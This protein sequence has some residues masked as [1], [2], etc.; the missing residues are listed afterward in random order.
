M[1][2]TKHFKVSDIDIRVT[3]KPIKN[4]HLSVHPPDGRVTLSSPPEFDLE[5]LRVYAATKLSWI[6]KERKKILSQER[7]GIKLYV[8]RESHQFLGKR[9]LLE[10]VESGRPKLI[11]LQNKMLLRAVKGATTEQKEK[12]LYNWYRKQLREIVEGLSKKHAAKMGIDEYNIGIRKMRTKWGS[13]TVDKR[14]WFNVELAK[15]PL[16][17]IEYVVV[18]E[19]VHILEK[20][21]NKRFI[22]LM[23]EYLPNWRLRKKEL[24]ELPLRYF[25]GK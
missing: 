13:C 5:K 7:E 8:T 14:L 4:L 9:Y 22:L 23:D 2:L 3:Y 25:S 20:H 19:L 18:H 1:R 16:E 15:K 17:C 24:N 10:V 21:H 6:K 12:T 11:L